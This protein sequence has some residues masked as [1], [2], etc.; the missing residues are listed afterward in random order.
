M[1]DW[2]VSCVHFGRVLASISSTVAFSARFARA[3]RPRVRAALRRA[4]PVGDL[5]V[6][7]VGG[8]S[9]DGG[10]SEK[11]SESECEKMWS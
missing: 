2:G 3:A 6:F 9:G 10:G 7:D 1:W 11:K 8:Q 4:A 5:L